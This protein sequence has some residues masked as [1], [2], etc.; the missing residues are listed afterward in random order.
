MN[1]AEIITVI[2]NAAKSRM[3]DRNVKLPGE[4]P[5]YLMLDAAGN[6][7]IYIEKDMTEGVSY[8]VARV[9]D[10]LEFAKSVP[11]RYGVDRAKVYRELM[12]LVDGDDVPTA[13]SLS[14]K[15]D[16]PRVRNNAVNFQLK[17]HRDFLRWMGAKNLTQTQFR[18]L[19]IELV[20]QHDCPD[21]GGQL[22]ILNYKVEINFDSAVETERNTVLAFQAK[23][24][25]GEFQVPKMITVNCPVVAGAEFRTN[26]QFEVVIIRPSNPGDKIKFSLEP[27]GKDRV[28]LLREAY[29]SV[30][31]TEILAPAQIIIKEFAETI[32]PVYI[33]KR[34][35]PHTVTMVDSTLMKITPNG[36]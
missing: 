6:E 33:R 24:I 8:D 16:D 27:Y 4:R 31:D 13:V 34:P 20:D 36:R 28:H 23:E 29:G 7:T 26:I 5:G 1:I 2:A 3:I 32:P 14:D 18:N 11:S 25:Q 19:V 12:V 35:E 10:F 21:L 17:P 30:V 15:A 22:Q 9:A